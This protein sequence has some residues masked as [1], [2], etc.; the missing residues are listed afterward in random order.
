MSKHF[1]AIGGVSYFFLLQLAPNNSCIKK[2]RIYGGS[3]QL[4]VVVMTSFPNWYH[5]NL[6]GGCHDSPYIPTEL[7]GANCRGGGIIFFFQGGAGGGSTKNFYCWFRPFRTK[8]GTSTSWQ[9]KKFSFQILFSK[10]NVASLKSS[11]SGVGGQKPFLR[12]WG[13]FWRLHRGVINFFFQQGAAPLQ[14]HP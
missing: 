11:K 4:F 9:K 2:L 13:W 5:S 3:W 12:G 6:N 8:T 10:K 7:F 14:P 1:G